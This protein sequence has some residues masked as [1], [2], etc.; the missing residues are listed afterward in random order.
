[1]L[2]AR[3]GQSETRAIE[4]QVSP[5]TVA[6]A[7]ARK[8]PQFWGRGFDEI[9]GGRAAAQACGEQPL[10]QAVAKEPGN[11]RPNR[12]A[13]HARKAEQIKDPPSKQ[14]AAGTRCSDGCGGRPLGAKMC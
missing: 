5:E 3:E 10:N 14:K 4:L 2:L 12:N 7:G 11:T 9:C 6:S 8:W 1:M 13:A